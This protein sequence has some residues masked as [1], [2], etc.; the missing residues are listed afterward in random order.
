MSGH[1]PETEDPARATALKRKILD[2]LTD[3]SRHY[4]ALEAAMAEFGTAF[5]RDDFA[6]AATSDE[7]AALN[8]VK[9]VERGLDQLLNYV[10]ELSALGLEL[11]GL[12]SPDEEPHARRDL[13]RL[14]D[15]DVIDEQLRDALARVAAIRNR[16][17]HDYVGVSALDVHE[18][19]GVLHRALPRFVAGYQEWLK[20]GFPG[21][22]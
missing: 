18:A 2:R 17:V 1:E 12:R 16:M 13:T 5:A 9:A 21:T 14:R 19:A 11:A 20:A 15:I 3:I 8:R 6:A 7:P 10:A 22:R 4:R